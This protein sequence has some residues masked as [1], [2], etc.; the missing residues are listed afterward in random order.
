[1]NFPSAC[2]TNEK[3]QC[4]T[5]PIFII[6]RCIRKPNNDSYK[7]QTFN[8][9]LEIK[10]YT[11]LKVPSQNIANKIKL[12]KA[13]TTQDTYLGANREKDKHQKAKNS[14]K[15]FLSNGRKLIIGAKYKI[16]TK[17]RPF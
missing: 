5:L 3:D 1:M 8:I 17:Q 13:S 11:S 16:E 15:H 4:I 7:T 10:I 12:I 9:A 14:C 6:D 2:C